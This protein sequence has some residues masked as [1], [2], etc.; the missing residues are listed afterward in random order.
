MKFVMFRLVVSIIAF[1]ILNIS[2]DTD[3]IA[4]SSSPEV[5]SYDDIDSYTE[6]LVENMVGDEGY[7]SEEDDDTGEPSNQALEKFSAPILFYEGYP[8]FYIPAI[9]YKKLFQI[10][11]NQ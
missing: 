7:T 2:I 3:Y 10:T 8:K 1:Q 11:L 5:H 6:F 4:Y 9:C